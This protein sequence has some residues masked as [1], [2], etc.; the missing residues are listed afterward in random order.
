MELRKTREPSAMAKYRINPVWAIAG[1]VAAMLF[2]GCDRGGQQMPVMARPPARVTA[3]AAV[4]RDVPIYLEEIGRTVPVE[5]VSIMPQ[6][7]GKV[8]AAHVNDGDYVKK[9]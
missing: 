6:V 1:L 3:A 2:A 4:T 5:M 7:G 8:V 9:G